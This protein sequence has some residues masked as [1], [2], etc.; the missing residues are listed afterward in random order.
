MPKD[1]DC[2]GC[3]NAMRFATVSAM[4]IH[5]E[6]GKCSAG[7]TTRHLNALSNEAQHAREYVVKGREP[8][9]LAGVPCRYIQDTDFNERLGRWTCSVCAEAF[10]H[11]PSLYKHLQNQPCSRGYPEVFKCPICPEKFTRL[12]GMLQHMETPRC[13][14]T[15]DTKGVVSLLKTLEANL[16]N[17]KLQ[18]TLDNI[19]YNLEPDPYR[20]GK[21]IVKVVDVSEALPLVNN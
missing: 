8:W 21:L 17:P 9:L 10:I 2:W 3:G 16:V 14:V 6:S 1:L 12:S 4:T 15:K 18:S 5:L 19:Q 13:P 11:K 7:W 20:E